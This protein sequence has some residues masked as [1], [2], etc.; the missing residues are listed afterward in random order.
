MFSFYKKVFFFTGFTPSVFRGHNKFSTHYALFFFLRKKK[1]CQETTY[2]TE[3][4]FE[5]KN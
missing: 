1:A 3:F 5:D 2:R 4:V